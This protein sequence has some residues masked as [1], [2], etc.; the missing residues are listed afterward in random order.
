MKFIVWI[1]LL[2][3]SVMLG[4][5]GGGGGGGSSGG[6][7]DGTTPPARPQ[8]IISG[9]VVVPSPVV[10]ATVTAYEF[11]T[12]KKGAIIGSAA[13]TDAAGAF[14]I[15]S[16]SFNNYIYLE[17]K[18]GN[19]TEPA[20]NVNIALEPDHLFAAIVSY[21]PGVAVTVNVTP[22]TTLATALSLNLFSM[23]N[24]ATTSLTLASNRLDGVLGFVSAPLVPVDPS[25][26]ASLTSFNNSVF[27]GFLLAGV[28]QWG[29]DQSQAKGLLPNQVYNIAST[30]YASYLDLLDDGKIGGSNVYTVGTVPMTPNV[31]R[32]DVA[33]STLKF[34]NSMRNNTGFNVTFL[35]PQ[36]TTYNNNTDAI[37]NSVATVALN[38]NHP[39]IASF[40][41]TNGASKNNTF[42][43]TATV[44]DLIGFTSGQLLMDGALVQSIPVTKEQV[45][46]VTSTAIPTTTDNNT[47]YFEMLFTNAVGQK[48]STGQIAVAFDN[49]GPVLYNELGPGGS[50]DSVNTIAGEVLVGVNN[51][52]PVTQ[53][54]HW[55]IAFIPDREKNLSVKLNNISATYI[56]TA[57]ACATIGTSCVVDNYKIYLPMNGKTCVSLNI[58]IRDTAGNMN[59][60]PAGHQTPLSMTLR[61]GNQCYISFTVCP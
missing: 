6:P 3:V 4:A 59:I 2:A 54:C 31:L 36:L 50:V 17:V 9:K 8:A 15:T 53:I 45:Q 7:G 44:Q 16:N 52:D 23:G 29:Y 35:L 56:A 46:G 18:N 39:S 14:A 42:T 43:F 37:F 25:R 47:H 13:L 10:G 1:S 41:P 57:N 19:Y 40:T 58:D 55:G 51:Y 22:Y 61:P 27:Y 30:T 20:S 28:S 21:T 11:D 12:F 38:E 48:I 5:C 60:I 26:S 24:S 49:A 33:V 32:H 34:A